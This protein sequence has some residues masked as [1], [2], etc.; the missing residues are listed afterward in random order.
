MDNAGER[1]ALVL[2]DEAP[3]A[4]V[5]EPPVGDGGGDLLHGVQAE[6][7]AVGKDRGAQRA[8]VPGVAPR[9]AWPL[10]VDAAPEVVLD[11]DEQVGEPDRATAGVQP[12]V[13]VDQAVRVR[14]GGVRGRVRLQRP[15]VVVEHDLPVV[16]NTL[17]EPVECIRQ[18]CVQVLD[19]RGGIA[20][21][22]GA[23]PK[24]VADRLP[25][26]ARQEER[27]EAADVLRA[28][29]GEVARLDLVVHREEQRAL[30]AAVP[31]TLFRIG[32]GGRLELRIGH[33]GIV[34]GAGRH[35]AGD[36]ELGAKINLIAR[37]DGWRP[38]LALLGG[39]SLPTGD[40]GFSS[41]GV[42]PSFLVA[43]AHELRPR[44]SLG[45]NVGAAWESSADRLNR[46]AF[47]V[48]SLVLGVRLTDR[49]GTFLELF[50]DR[51]TTGTSAT[52]ASVDGGLTWLVTDIV[53]VDVS[54]GRG[55]WGPADDVFVGTGLSFRLPR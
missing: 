4:D 37:A 49:L 22:S 33:V 8:H 47:L 28:V 19:R 5:L 40:H 24:R 29:D 3:I 43:F 26:R 42:D 54:V 16:R 39:L 14:R 7:A 34:G 20:G 9:L 30:P 46:D 10:A 17:E 21:E 55:L 23:R 13:Q 18:T 11:L 12:A 52:S 6:I 41:D 44:L 53:Q 50:G 48:Y 1:G 25:L 51:Q 38:E 45:Y 31:G 15:P 32:L 36:S 35:G 2:L 27:L